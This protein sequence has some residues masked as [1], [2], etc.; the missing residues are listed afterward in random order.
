MGAPKLKCLGSVQWF[1]EVFPRLG[2]SD[3]EI[4]LLTVGFHKGTSEGTSWFQGCVDVAASG[5]HTNSPRWLLSEQQ[6]T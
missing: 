1:E 2:C 5:G 6:F 3:S 4:P